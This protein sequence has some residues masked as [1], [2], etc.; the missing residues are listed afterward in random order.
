MRQWKALL[1]GFST[2]Q[3]IA[4]VLAAVAVASGLVVF[5]R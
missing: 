2:G 1:A 3:K 4:L 5:T